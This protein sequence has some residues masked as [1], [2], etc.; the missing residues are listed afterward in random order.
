M[1]FTVADALRVEP[2]S[3]GKLIA[4]E[5]G[6]ANAIQ[7]VSVLEVNVLDLPQTDQFVQEAILVISSMYSVMD[8]IPDQVR[9][10]RLLHVRGS[11]GFVLCHIGMVIKEVSQELIDV[12]NELS[13]PL[14]LMPPKIG[15]K[16][17]IR[18]VS[19][20]LLDFQNQRLRDAI[21][22]YDYI[23]S[24]LIAAKDN[25]TLVSALEKMIGRKVFYFNHNGTAIYAPGVQGKLINSVGEQIK[26]NSASFIL[27]NSEIVVSCAETDEPILL[28]PVRSNASY[29]GV[30]AIISGTPLSEMDK[31]AIAQTRNA[32]SISTL[33]RIN[34]IQQR[35]HLIFEFINDIINGRC[36]DERILMSRSASLK[37]DIA[38][39]HGVILLDIF[40]FK[41]MSVTKSEEELLNIK[42]ELIEHVEIEL[43]VLS[44]GSVCCGVSDKIIILFIENCTKE[45]A[46]QSMPRIGQALQHSINTALKLP[47]SVGI[48]SYCEKVSDIKKSY[49]TAVF[50]AQIASGFLKKP[51]CVNCEDFPAYVMLLQMYAG[52]DELI[53]NVVDDM[54]SP[55]RTQDKKTNSNLEETFRMLLQCDMDSNLVAKNLYLHKNT[56]L[57]RKRKIASLYKKDPFSL[58]YRRQFEIAFTLE[59]LLPN[60]S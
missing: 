26:N 2:L 27:K 25:K 55:I 58:P 15:Y 11:A 60:D 47:I 53:K 23:T 49:E 16:E 28:Y 37:C 1:S 33:N 3:F 24:L 31:I 42:K 52:N 4:G 17:I 8:S 9:M 6:V 41:R 32:L 19:D 21:K 38:H 29:F 59:S 36:E 39:V 51:S 12:C 45:K 40:E 43:S 10:M 22:I 20:A 57:Q 34:V 7:D 5:K 48:G 56:V 14:I 54:L 18:A 44:G 46:C 13:F 35:K 50:A 30:L